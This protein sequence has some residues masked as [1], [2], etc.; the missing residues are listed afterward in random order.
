MTQQQPP[1]MPQPLNYQSP[2]IACP[3]CR[4]TAYKPVSFTWWGGLLGPKILHHVKCLGCGYCFN[5][6]TG[7]SNTVAIIVYS[8]VLLV[9]MFVFLGF[10]FRH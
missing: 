7:R 3:R 4:H 8:V 1:P 10:V 2:G 9:V 6:K 5:S